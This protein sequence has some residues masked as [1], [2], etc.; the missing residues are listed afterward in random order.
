MLQRS[1]LSYKLEF[2]VEAEIVVDADLEPE[3]H[4]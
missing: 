2:N 4:I 3:Y 1:N